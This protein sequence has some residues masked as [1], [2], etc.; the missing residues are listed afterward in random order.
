MDINLNI[1]YSKLN[2]DGCFKNH[3]I[4]P[5][6]QREYVW[7]ENEV[8]QLLADINDAYNTNNKKP[9]FLGMTVVYQGDNSSLEL[10]DGQQRITTF[11]ILLCVLIHRYKANNE[12]A[13][14]YESRIYSPK[15]DLDGNTVDSYC[16]ELQYA[17]SS[18]QLDN[19]YHGNIPMIDDDNL[20]ISDARLY[21]AYRTIDKVLKQYYP[22]FNDFKKFGAFVF[23]M[24]QFVQIETKDISDALKIFETIN[25]RGVGLNS[26]DLLKNMIFMQVERDDFQRLNKLWKDII[27]K[28]EDI[29][30]KPLRF[31]RY[32]ITAKYDISDADGNINGILPE[33]NI[34][35]WLM[36]NAKQCGYQSNPFGFVGSM[37]DDLN[38]YAKF[39]NPTVSTP[40]ASYLKNIFLI[41]GTSYRLHMVMLMAASNMDTTTQERFYQIIESFV[42]YATINRIKANVL[43]KLV[44]AWC[45]EIRKIKD[46]ND[47]VSFVNDYL[48]PVV[49]DWNSNYLYNF[50]SLNINNIQKYRISY[51]LARIGKYVNER[52]TGGNNCAD[53]KEFLDKKY[54]IE[55][56]MPQTCEDKGYYDVDD[57]EFS[58]YVGRLGNLTL[59]EKTFNSSIQNKSFAEK[60]LVYNN[61]NYYLTVTISK[62][63]PVG[64]NTVAD[65]MNKELRTWD[66][67]NKLSIDD[68]QKLLYELSNKIWGIDA[69]LSEW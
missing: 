14:T 54:T 57:E 23:N 49:E 64:K 4:V 36:A 66:D 41:A 34:Y 35:N 51:I 63:D 22:D 16:L 45:P 44:A 9:Y 37:T 69:I 67:W 58:E 1:E 43:E 29:N 21:G 13:K 18:K 62:I 28:L 2:L 5:D 24:V 50:M 61:S 68:R 55:H 46:E 48:S 33:N 53:V 31:L 52:R 60:C 65:K 3:Y 6:Y 59:L 40:G 39:L 47:L 11:F 12:S 26:M 10:I 15:M 8:E 17:S 30:E 27:D 20:S 42:Y 25:Q 7:K 38:R 19:I 56:I 32:F